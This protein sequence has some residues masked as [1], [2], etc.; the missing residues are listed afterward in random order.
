MNWFLFTQVMKMIHFLISSSHE[1]V[2]E[3]DNKAIVDK[4][5]KNYNLENF[6]LNRIR[7]ISYL[8]CKGK[9]LMMILR[10]DSLSV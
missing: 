4:I 6:H 8:R 2:E 9:N 1:Q 10:E 5:L 3:L 7:K